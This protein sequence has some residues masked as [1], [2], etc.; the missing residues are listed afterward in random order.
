MAETTDVV[1]EKVEVNKDEIKNSEEK[2]EI[3]E[4]NFPFFWNLIS[5]Q[6]PI[7]IIWYFNIF[8]SLLIVFNCR[9]LNLR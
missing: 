3:K 7:G 6:K 9:E 4:G 2:E 8:G 5:M 1:S